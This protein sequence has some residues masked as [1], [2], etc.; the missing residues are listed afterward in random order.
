MSLPH[1][2][3]R[4]LG[5]VEVVR[6]G[7]PLNL[8]G[9]IQRHIL[10]AL[11]LET[12]RTISTSRLAAVAWGVDP[13]ATAHRQVQNRI[14]ALRAVLTAA[15]AAPVLKST[16]GG[17]R[18]SV[19]PESVD[20]LVFE[21][22]CRAGATSADLRSALALWRGPALAGLGLAQEAA[23]LEE[24]RL[25]AL[26]RCLELELAAGQ[27]VIADLS[28]LVHDQ[29]FR[30]RPVELLMTA[31]YQAGRQSEALTCFRDF[32][33]HLADELG[34]DPSAELQ[35]LHER[36][37]RADPDLEPPGRELPSPGGTV[38][39]G[40]C[41]LPSD[42]VDFTGREQQVA[43]L[44]RVLHPDGPAEA[45]V[46]SAIAGKGGVGKTALAVHAAHGLRAD[47]PD[48][49]LYV[50][51][52]G[53]GP[54]PCDPGDVL[55]GLLLVLGV[56][57]RLI[58]G[59]LSERAALYRSRL[60]DK[61]ILVLLDNAADEAQ[62]RPLLPG[63]PDCRVLITSRNRLVGLA[64]ARTVDLGVLPPT[65]ATNL[66]SKIA[67]VDRVKAEPVAAAEIVRLC[68][69]LPLAVRIAGARL[70]ARQHRPL[71]WL[72]SRLADEHRRLDELAAGDL[73]VRAS[74]AL[75]YEGLKPDLQRAFRLLGVIRAPDF[76]PWVLSALLDVP[77]AEAEDLLESLVDAQLVE[78]DVGDH[79]RYRLHDLLRVY[80]WERL[81]A[82]ESEGERRAAI[83]RFL[84]AS[85][86]LVERA[87]EQPSSRVFGAMHG[88][89]CRWP[90]PASATDHLIHDVS[91][92]FRVERDVLVDAVRL[93]CESGFSE[94]AWDLAGSMSLH[95]ARIGD[96]D[97]WRQTHQGALAEVREVDDHR[98]EAVLLLGLAH[99]EGYR[100][101][102]AEAKAL[103]RRAAALFER[104]DDQYGLAL[105]KAN[106]ASKL[107][108]EGRFAEVENMLLAAM[109]VLRQFDPRACVSALRT[110]GA[111]YLEQGDAATAS[112]RLTEGLD[113]ARSADFLFGE[114]YLLCWLARAYGEQ[115]RV[116][117]AITLAEKATA[118]FG[119]MHE[120]IGQ[121]IALQ[122]C[123]ELYT[124]RNRTEEALAALE[125]SLSSHREMGDRGGEAHSLRALGQLLLST[126]EHLRAIEYLNDAI[127]LARSINRLV[128]AARSLASL[129][130]AYKAIGDLDRAREAHMESGEFYKRAS[131]PTCNQGQLTHSSVPSVNT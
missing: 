8:G 115:D 107:A 74:F 90:L 15:G 99:L 130:E 100:E 10:A 112:E 54:Q 84:G 36:I 43:E 46:V 7:V 35:R 105:V 106:G 5:P 16:T 66:L 31:L 83:K 34:L 79:V 102:G 125:S 11:I 59:N 110:L 52:D 27:P 77:L 69:Y 126:G 67:G 72:V 80:A 19:P 17:Y 78:V 123:G 45:V 87:S 37:L 82:D 18:L 41:L 111:T 60:A 109:P 73:E 68:G 2:E 63:S 116:D 53:A 93:A 118:I 33:A 89:A 122:E 103:E 1:L 25:A 62:V 114:A 42:V 95:F 58:P 64:G 3:Y 14:A 44:R 94:F 55:H 57:G 128:L 56:E 75:S 113:L 121:A 61:R 131:L 65:Q 48:G 98:G 23:A 40:L 49:Q 12:N 26:E 30:E 9:Q 4:V 85:L 127:E 104:L 108:V 129:S 124:R 91:G 92:W 71:S 88:S 70:A 120:R 50:N 81:A 22:L 29:P 86:W 6:D 20:A 28:A 13:P 119:R 21:D 101:R 39:R 32:A 76:A 38:S 117:E 97:N 96:D 47:F 24:K 51:L